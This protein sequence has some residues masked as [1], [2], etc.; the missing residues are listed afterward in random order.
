MA[1]GA[2]S[3]S[4]ASI[5]MKKECGPNWDHS[6]GRIAD[7]AIDENMTNEE[8]LIFLSHFIRKYKRVHIDKSNRKIK[9]KR[10]DFN[11]HQNGQIQV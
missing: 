4:L 7:R 9:S 3:R 8:L 6:A 1:T 11:K 5:R 10:K 2:G